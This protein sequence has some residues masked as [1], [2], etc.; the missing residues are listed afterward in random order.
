MAKITEFNKQNLPTIRED[1]NKL[2]AEYTKKTGIKLSLGNI[3]FY[4]GSFTAKLE[5]TIPNAPTKSDILLEKAM[6][7]LGLKREGRDGRVLTG[8]KSTRWAYP[9][10]YIHNGRPMKCSADVAKMYFGG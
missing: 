3:T 8:Y 1:L 6:T 4:E 2:L 9:F 5:A 7:Q 10:S